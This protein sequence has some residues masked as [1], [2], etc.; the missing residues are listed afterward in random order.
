M[1]LK[2]PNGTAFVFFNTARQT[3]VGTDKSHI[4]SILNSISIAVM[5]GC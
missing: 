1:N 2:G 4:C 3:A 5:L